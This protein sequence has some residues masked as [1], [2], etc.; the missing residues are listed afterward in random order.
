MAETERRLA[1]IMFS[2]I[3]GY[4]ALMG[5]NEEAGMRVRER[6]RA[7]LG[8][9]AEAN[10]GRIADENGDELVLIFP[11][12]LDAV[13]CALGVQRKLAED[14]DLKLRIGIHSGDVVFEG[15]RI[16]GD[17]VNVA[18]RIRPLAQAGGICVSGQV[19]DSIKSHPEIECTP[20]GQKRLRNVNRPVSV[21]AVSAIGSS[22]AGR[23]TSVA[24]AP[25]R[26][27]AVRWALS[28]ASALLVLGFLGW[29]LVGPTATGGEIRS[30]QKN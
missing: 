1:A 20:L 8:P 27:G 6:H 7:L 12:A 22:T 16:Y 25:R 30:H 14:P 3:V 17:G 4:T 5:E 18:S 13:T 9:L 15:E 2:D 10:H 11:S 19:Y 29:W 28:G 24:R 21:V 23:R 26:G